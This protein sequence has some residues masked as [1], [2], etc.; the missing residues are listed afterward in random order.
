MAV[1]AYDEFTSSSSS[2]S[3]VST[4]TII[5]IHGLLGCG[6]DFADFAHSLASNLSASHASAD[7]RMVT[8]DLRNHGR[9]T[10]IEGLLPPHDV[11]NTA[12]DIANCCD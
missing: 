6:N 11:E 3:S 10:D 9:S 7:W 2:L 5:L 8:M 1:I 4:F 12:R